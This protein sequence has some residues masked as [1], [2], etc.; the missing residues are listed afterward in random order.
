MT[1]L[2]RPD[3]KPVFTW[4][5]EW[6]LELKILTYLTFVKT[7]TPRQVFEQI[8][9]DAERRSRIYEAC[10][11]MAAKFAMK[12]DLDRQITDIDMA[13]ET[14]EAVAE[15]F[16]HAVGISSYVELFPL[17]TVHEVVMKE[18]WSQ[19]D[20][21]G[22]RTLAV[23]ANEAIIKR[24][25]FDPEPTPQ[26]VLD[27]LTIDALFGDEVPAPLR[28]HMAKAIDAGTRDPSRRRN[29]GD[30]LFGASEP[31][32]TFEALAEHLDVTVLSAPF[33]AYAKSLGLAEEAGGD[34]AAESTAGILPPEAL[35]S[36]PPTA[37]APDEEEDGEPE[38]SVSGPAS[39]PPDAE[40]ED[41]EADDLEELEPP[42]EAG[43]ADAPSSPPPLGKRKRERRHADQG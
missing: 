23:F 37:A 1:T 40:I 32:V 2:D 22:H 41:V 12:F 13:I 15:K 14:D 38:I 19:T 30:I 16:V 24:D 31:A 29:V 20:R 36:I 6:L 27:A 33:L 25:A 4:M 17:R 39:V 11:G 9:D 21:P 42:A 26:T 28:V 8:Q 34:A 35:D 10:T 5:L 3:P 7:I 18:D 43:A